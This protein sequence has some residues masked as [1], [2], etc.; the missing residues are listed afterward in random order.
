MTLR[1]KFALLVACCALMLLGSYY[2]F[3]V[4]TARQAIVGYNAQAGARLSAAFVD[5]KQVQSV[6]DQLS[7]QSTP[8]VLINSLSQQFNQ[9][10]FV[11][12]QEEKVIADNITSQ[13]YQFSFAALN[14]SYQFSVGE[15][16]TRPTIVQMTSPQI[17]LAQHSLF[18]IPQLVVSQSKQQAQIE[19]RLRNQFLWALLGLSALAIIL[20]WFTAGYFLRPLAD[21]QQ[22]LIA[23]QSGQFDT[24]ISAARNDEVGRLLQQF[25][26]LATWL[27]GLHQQYRQMN[28]D[29]AH[30]LRS[31]LN[32]V[33]SRLE[34]LQDQLLSPTS[35]QFR[36][37][38]EEL[39]VITKLVDDLRL[40]S[41]TESNNLQVTMKPVDLN[42]LAQQVC[43]RYQYQANNSGVTLTLEST[44]R[45]QVM[46]DPQRAQQILVNLISNAITYGA[47]GGKVVINLFRQG[48]YGCASVSDQGQ[49]LTPQ[50]QQQVFERFFRTD[51]SRGSKSVGL[52]LSI[53]AQLA[54]LQNGHLTVASTP[55]QGA[56]FTLSLLH[57]S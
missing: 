27:Q 14:G 26:Q 57:V 30:E 20:S 13:G 36:V 25:N 4:S 48:K 19:Q 11:I 31:P 33:M 39:R 54:Q 6:V 42:D 24:R 43:E 8:Q 45:V 56:T 49:G 32:A 41:L 15:P 22:G 44:A 2:L 55:G 51:K 52:G 7:A 35:D 37:M 21:V 5:T 17:S 47:S 34:A 18:Y 46:A 38:H 3:S 10:F 12:T 1:T 29:L 16:G 40:L 28:D 50:Q 23:L 53:S 9:S